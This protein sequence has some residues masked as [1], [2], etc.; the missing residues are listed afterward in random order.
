MIKV[1]TKYSDIEE[2]GM[3]IRGNNSAPMG[4]IRQGIIE[5]VTADKVL[6]DE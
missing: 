6:K 5:E 3:K 1:C 4:G 2:I